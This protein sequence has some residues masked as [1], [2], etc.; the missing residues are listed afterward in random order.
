[1]AVVVVVHNM[2]AKSCE[3]KACPLREAA[4]LLRSKLRCD[5]HRP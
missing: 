5:R 1:V 3:F 4:K 2:R